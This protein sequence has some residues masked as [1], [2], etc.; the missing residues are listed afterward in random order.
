MKKKITVGGAVTL[1]LMLATVTFIMTMIY[2]QNSFDSRVYNIKER[3]TMYSKLAEV[4]QLVRRD[5]YTEIDEEKLTD[6]LIV[7]Y[8]EGIGDTNARYLTAEKYKEE[9]N[10]SQGRTVGIGASFSQDVSGYIL[11]TDVTSESPADLM[12]LTVGDLITKVDDIAVTSDNY[13]EAVAAISGEAGTTVTLVVHHESIEKICTIT[14]RQVEV[15][16]VNVTSFGTIAYIDISEFSDAT[17]SEFSLELASLFNAGV[18]GLVIDLRDT[19]GGDIDSMLDVADRIVPDG[20]LLSATYKSGESKVLRT[21]DEAEVDLPIAVIINENTSGA[22]ELFAQILKDCKKASI[23]GTRSSGNCSMT[24]TQLLSDGSAVV[25][26]TAV[27]NP[28]VSQS[29]D[30]KGVNPDYDVSLSVSLDLLGP[31]PDPTNDAQLKKAIEAAGGTVQY[32]E[33]TDN[34]TESEEDGSEDTDESTD[35]TENEEDETAS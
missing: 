14:R 9:L 29:F 23:V 21:A 11:I 16:T 19:V 31:V 35:D 7:G 1:A 28:P 24:E 6:G 2:A 17:P 13:N 33:Q 10:A 27:Y 4:D 32:E 3:E 26:T 18:T 12:E 22:P 5:F 34:D 15:K 25:I 8:L 20:V 30:G